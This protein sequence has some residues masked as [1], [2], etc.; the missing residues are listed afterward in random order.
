M[1]GDPQKTVIE[2]TGP[3][4][5]MLLVPKSPSILF[6]FFFKPKK[7]SSLFCHVPSDSYCLVTS[8]FNRL[9][10]IFI[11][12]FISWHLKDF[13]EEDKH[14]VIHFFREKN[15]EN[16]SFLQDSDQTVEVLLPR[17]YEFHHCQDGASFDEDVSFWKIN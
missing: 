12:F 17:K 11:F 6:F 7:N 3:H 4:R 15:K 2:R 1:C 10:F 8:L 13:L 9:L 5:R 16:S 14:K